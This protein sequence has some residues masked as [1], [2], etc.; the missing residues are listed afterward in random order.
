MLEE[1][2]NPK[3]VEALY[4]ESLLDP[5]GAA[6]QIA[7]RYRVNLPELNTEMLKSAAINAERER[8]YSGVGL[9]TQMLLN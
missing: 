1:G 2:M 4:K 8:I 9:K 3:L 7:K 5:T 6:A